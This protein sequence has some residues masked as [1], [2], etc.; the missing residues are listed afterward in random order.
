ERR[1]AETAAE[2]RRLAGTRVG[3]TPLLQL[4]RRPEVTYAD[5]QRLDPGA[6]RDVAV[7][8]QVE[9]SAK[10]EGYIRRM[11]DDVA[12]FKRLEERRIP[13][14]LHFR[15]IPG[16]ST[17]IRGRLAEGRPRSPGPGPRLPG[18]APAARS[19]LTLRGPRPRRAEAQR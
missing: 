7:A 15:A 3:G 4:L 16:L 2:I 13:D 14:G 19:R 5:L 1:R 17:E 11:L 9:V 18:V 12:R 6:I 8:R 10:Y